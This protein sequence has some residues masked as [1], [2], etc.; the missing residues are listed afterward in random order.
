MSQYFAF[1]RD[2]PTMER[3]CALVEGD[4]ASFIQDNK[5]HNVS[6]IYQLFK[7]LDIVRMSEAVSKT[8]LYTAKSFGSRGSGFVLSGGEFMDRAPVPENAD[9]RGMVVK[10]IKNEEIFIE[11]IP[12]RPIPCDRDLWFERVWGKYRELT[13]S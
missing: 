5:W 4:I 12:V 3:E 9:G 13:G 1:L 8:I 10:L 11:C 7:N 2:I 6:E